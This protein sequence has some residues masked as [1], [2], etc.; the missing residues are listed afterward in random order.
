MKWKQYFNFIT[1]DI[2]G[3][4]IFSCDYLPVLL[5]LKAPQFYVDLLEVWVDTRQ[6]R[7]VTS[8]NLYTGNVIFFNNKFIRFRGNC[9][10]DQK[11]HEKGVYRLKHILENNGE[12]KCDR[13]FVNLGMGVNDISVLRHIYEKI[14]LAW[15]RN[16]REEESNISETDFILGGNTIISNLG[17]KQIYLQLLKKEE[18]EPPIFDRIKRKVESECPIFFIQ[19]WTFTTSTLQSQETFFNQAC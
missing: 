15:K 2:G 14:P 5:K 4:F 17:S 6:I 18:D 19:E 1:R 9:I 13:Y 7:S 3:E 11:M 8:N 12:L 10:Y 16:V